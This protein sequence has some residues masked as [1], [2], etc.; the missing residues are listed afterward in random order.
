MGIF[1]GGGTAKPSGTAGGDLTGTYPNPTIGAGKVV[2]ATVGA[3]AAIQISKLQALAAG[4]VSLT[5]GNL[6]TN[7]GA[8]VDATGLTVTLTTGARRCLVT[9]SGTAHSGSCS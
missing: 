6:T 8:F 3:A 9:F 1:S 2:D 5:T 7:T 4:K